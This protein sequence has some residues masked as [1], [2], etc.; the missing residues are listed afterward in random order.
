MPNHRDEAIAVAVDAIECLAEELVAFTDS[1]NVGG[2]EGSDTLIVGLTG[3]FLPAIL[4]EALTEMHEAAPAPGAKGGFSEIHWE[5]VAKN[6]LEVKARE[7]APHTP[8]PNPPSI[9]QIRGKK[10]LREGLRRRHG[11]PGS[12]N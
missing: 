7:K 6:R 9:L 11:G 5:P 2:E 8:K 3:E 12:Q 10:S 1:I 4:V